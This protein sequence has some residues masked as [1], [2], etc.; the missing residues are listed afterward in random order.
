MA[1]LFSRD[2]MI[3]ATAYI[4]ADSEEEAQ[5]KF[6]TLKGNGLEISEDD[7]DMIYGGQY[8]AGMPE[9]SLSPAMTI[10]GTFPGDDTPVG[11]FEV[12]EEELDPDPDDDECGQ[13]EGTGRTQSCSMSQEEEDCPVCDG[14]GRLGGDD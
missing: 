8:H 11:G 10:H 5:K 12:V 9:I 13:C 2:V 3:A 6:D 4:V 1:K 14:T 7:D